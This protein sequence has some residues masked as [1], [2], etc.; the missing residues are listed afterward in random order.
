MG[1]TGLHGGQGDSVFAQ[2]CGADDSILQFS[3]EAS[4]TFLPPEAAALWPF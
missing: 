4:S 2:Y 1:Y 3:R